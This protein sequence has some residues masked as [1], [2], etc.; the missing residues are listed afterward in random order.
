MLLYIVRHGRT[1]WND[2]RRVMGLSPVSLNSRGREMVESL[3]RFLAGEK[4]GTIYSGTLV[5]TMETASIL[6]SSWDAQIVEEP[7]LNES[8]YEKWVGKR[9]SELEKDEDFILYSAR[10]T[11]SSFSRNEGIA[12]IQERV[13]ASIDR[14]AREEKSGR[15][16]LVSH[17]DVIKPAIAH[18]LGTGLDSI[19][20]ISIANASVSLLDLPAGRTARIVYMNLM[21]WKWKSVMSGI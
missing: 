16:A 4:I 1:D 20:R 8:P 12:D 5:R 14:I 11:A 10:P 18:F 15:A 2:E 7:R 6:A 9:Y 21:P 13:L 17:S 19:H 3:G